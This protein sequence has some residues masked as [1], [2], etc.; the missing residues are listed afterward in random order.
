MLLVYAALGNIVYWFD[1]D[2]A[3]G[4]FELTRSLDGFFFV[5]FTALYHHLK[6]IAVRSFGVFQP[7]LGVSPE[8][9]ANI[10]H[11]LTSLPRGFAWLAIAFGIVVGAQAVFLDP[12][13]VGLDTATTPLPYRFTGIVMIYTVASMAALVIQAVRQMLIVSHLHRGAADIDL[14]RLRPAQ[15]FATLTARAGMGLTLFIA[16]N[17][18]L[19]RLTGDAGE[20]NTSLNALLTTRNVVAG[21]STLPWAT[22]TLRG[23]FPTLLLP[24]LL[25]LVTRLLGHVA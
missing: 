20:L 2:G 11:E 13:S 9:S 6:S 22:D 8:R 3:T 25:W 14:F 15:A 18:A 21:L 12:A 5:F 23:F 24:V 16:F 4:T 10:E 19:Q 1:C 7:M 17:V